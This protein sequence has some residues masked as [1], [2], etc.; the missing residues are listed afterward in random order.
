[1]KKHLVVVLAYDQLCTFEFGCAI[2][3]FGLARPE[4]KVDW[5][6]FAVSAVERGSIRAAGGLIFKAP[7]ALHLLDTADTIIIPGWRDLDAA[8]AP[9]LLK[10]LNAAHQRGARICSICSGV[11]LLAATG[12]LDGKS[13]TTHW[14]FA[15]QLAQR[16]P[17]I[18]VQPNALY[19]DEGQ[20]V[21]SAGSA[22]GLDM[23]LHLVRS[24]FGSKVANQVA[25]R[26]VI[27]PHR[28]GGQTQFVPSPVQ[29]DETGRLTKLMDWIRMH[30]AEPHTLRSMA[31]RAVMTTRTL[32]RKFQE[33]SGLTPIEW[34][35]NERITIAKDLLETSETSIAEVAL[36]AG[37]ASE[38]SFRRHFR[39]LVD[40]SPSTYRRQF[41]NKKAV[42]FK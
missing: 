11:F 2:E 42:F 27:A 31:S 20:I 8:P 3:I 1:M 24:D 39:R 17:R 12:L 5:Y 6:D 40:L 34:L 9:S 13:A 14:K 35:I 33:T 29:H 10:R 26:L 7:Y 4:L 37:F 38:E 19:V 32:Q 30:P 18:A 16:Y 15:T 21:T 36:S 25:Q 22:A 28:S 23:M 41:S